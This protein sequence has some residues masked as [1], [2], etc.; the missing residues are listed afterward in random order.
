MWAERAGEQGEW[1]MLARQGVVR[2]E[3]EIARVPTVRAIR[4]HCAASET[5]QGRGKREPETERWEI[6]E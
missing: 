4:R 2:M 6:T 1:S 3:A 5:S